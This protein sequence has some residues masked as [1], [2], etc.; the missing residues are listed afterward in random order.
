MTKIPKRI[1]HIY[2]APE[3]QPDKLPLVCQ[4]SLANVKLLHPD[5]EFMLFNEERMNAFMEAEFPEYRQTISSFPLPIQRF[6]FFRY[7]AVYRLGGFYF[8]L[9]IFLARDLSPLLEEECVF[10][11]EELTWSQYLRDEHDMDWELA[12]YGFGAAPGHPFLKAVISN[13]ARAQKEPKWAAQMM[14]GIPQW[15]RNPFIPPM[16]TGPGMVSR[17]FAENADLRHDVT[18]LFPPDVRDERTWHRFGSFGVH[19]MQASW[20]KRDGLLRTRLARLWE[21]RRSRILKEASSSRGPQREG[22]WNSL[23][24][25]PS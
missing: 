14:R 22:N 17:T 10:P 9:D 3:G 8:D 16:T 24:E 21:I 6:D 12:N 19:L 23:V 11:F 5:F 13:C 7:L 25:V 1:I 2:C 15:F 4:A 20:R 18:V